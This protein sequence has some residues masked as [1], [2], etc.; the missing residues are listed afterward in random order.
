MM[1]KQTGVYTYKLKPRCV[2]FSRQDVR[3]KEL[4]KAVGT[5][6]GQAWKEAHQTP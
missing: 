3:V 2:Q 5:S 4:A 6:H 1:N